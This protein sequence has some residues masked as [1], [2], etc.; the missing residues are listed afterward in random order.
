[1][2]CATKLTQQYPP[3]FRNVATLPCDIK[4]SNFLQILSKYGKMQTNCIFSAPILIP[5]RA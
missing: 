5:L 2:K 1:M 3:H 4:N